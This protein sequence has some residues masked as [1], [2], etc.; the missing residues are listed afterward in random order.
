MITAHDEKDDGPLTYTV[1]EA[2]RMAGLSRNAAYE[3]VKRGE[4]PTI[5]FGSRIRV[6]GKPWRAKLNGEA[7]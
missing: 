6:L 5:T 3:A 1:V 2:G 4:I 7:V